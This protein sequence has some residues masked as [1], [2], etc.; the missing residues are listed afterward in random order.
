VAGLDV[1]DARYGQ[2]WERFREVLGS[3]QR[4]K[5]VRLGGSVRDGTA[6]VW[7]DLDLQIVTD[8][9]HH[10][11]FVAAWPVWLAEVTP[12]VFARTPIAP[13]IINTLTADGLTVDL[14]IYAGEA[15]APFQAPTSHTVGMLSSRRFDDVG[16][17]LEYAVEEQLRGLAGPFISLIQ[18]EEHLRH[19][20]GVPHVLTLLTTV[21]VAETGAAPPGKHWNRTFTEEQ[22]TAAA[23]LPPTSATREG[24]TLFGLA[25]A[26]MIVDRA[27]PL[28]PRYGLTWP[29]ALAAVAAGRLKDCLD[30]DASDWLR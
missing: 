10:D 21:F 1:V 26:K 19:L 4:V 24:V 18:R 20:T 8:P 12:T 9:E 28:Y 29:S 17:A 23:S 14:A 7:S 11:A 16:E 5:E 3:D 6:D 27:R 22:R 30:I 25:V 2:L 13:F 15:P